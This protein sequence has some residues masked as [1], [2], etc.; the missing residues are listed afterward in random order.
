[1]ILVGHLLLFLAMKEF[2]KSV[3][4]W[5]RGKIVTGSHFLDHSVCLWTMHKLQISASN[6]SA[7][8]WTMSG[9]IETKCHVISCHSRGWAILDYY[10]SRW[11]LHKSYSQPETNCYWKVW[12]LTCIIIIC[13]WSATQRWLFAFI[14]WGRPLS[15]LLEVDSQSIRHDHVIRFRLFAAFSRLN[16]YLSIGQPSQRRQALHV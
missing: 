15:R 12:A 6:Q 5:R 14:A 4:I 1:M 8:A 13:M 7:H 10:H 16:N 11:I 9:G 2:W 3:K